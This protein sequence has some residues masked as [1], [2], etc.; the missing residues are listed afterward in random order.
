MNFVNTRFSR[1]KP[2]DID[3]SGEP[4]DDERRN[5]DH[6]RRGGE[7]DRR[8]HEEYLVAAGQRRINMIWECTQATIAVS[9]TLARI[10][11]SIWPA[12]HASPEALSNAFFL[13]VGFY[14]SRTNH[15]NIGGVGKKPVPRYDGR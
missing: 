8:D 2:M 9:I 5:A 15:S 1:F 3:R 12:E 14:F 13:I 7:S 11:V 6:E 10:I 4:P